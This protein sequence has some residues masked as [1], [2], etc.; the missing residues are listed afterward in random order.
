MLFPGKTCGHVVPRQHEENA[1]NKKGC[2][3]DQME[4]PAC[5]LTLFKL[6]PKLVLRWGDR[7]ER[8]DRGLEFAEGDSG[9]C[10]Q[11]GTAVHRGDMC[12]RVAQ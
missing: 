11:R 6:E 10:S 2:D 12:M 1:A 7:G 5:P 8:G 3:A 9:G 4:Q